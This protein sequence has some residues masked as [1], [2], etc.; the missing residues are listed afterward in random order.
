MLFRKLFTLSFIIIIPKCVS[1]K[2]NYTDITVA[3]HL[4]LSCNFEFP[5]P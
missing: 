4:G 2:F 5:W 3:F 1:N